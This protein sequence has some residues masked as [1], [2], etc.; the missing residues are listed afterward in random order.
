[1]K[2][3]TCNKTITKTDAY[4]MKAERELHNCPLTGTRSWR[5]VAHHPICEECM[6]AED[7]LYPAFADQLGT[8]RGYYDME[9]RT[10]FEWDDYF[11]PQDVAVGFNYY[12]SEEQREEKAVWLSKHGMSTTTELP[13]KW[14]RIECVQ[15]QQMFI[16]EFDFRRRTDCCSDACRAKANKKAAPLH[17][18]DCASCGS[19]FTPKRSDAKTCSP[20][21]RQR[22]SREQRRHA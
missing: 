4:L 22:W 18:K 17:M 14:M 7:G 1:M 6:K 12:D 5:D 15:C 20:A 3:H 13:P 10:I 16:Q 2:C 21:C 8:G 11:R 9:G 19:L